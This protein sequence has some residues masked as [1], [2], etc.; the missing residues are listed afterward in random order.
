LEALHDFD[1]AIALG[2][3]WLTPHYNGADALE[4][5]NRPA[6]SKQAKTVAETLFRT[7]SDGKSTSG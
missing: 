3:E 1:K 7:D 6:E 4:K 5:L 2:P